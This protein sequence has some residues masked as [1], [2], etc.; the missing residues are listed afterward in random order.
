[1]RRGFRASILHFVADPSVDTDAYQYFDDGLLLI[2]GGRV[3]A[4]GSF[5]ELAAEFPPNQIEDLS[6]RLIVP[7]FIDAHVHFPQLEMIGAYGEALLPWLETYTFPT[8]GKFADSAYARQVAE[9][10]LD[11]LLRHGTTSALVFASVHAAATEALFEAA[12]ARRMRLIAGK[13]LMD[14]NA[15]AYLCDTPET[16]YAESRALIERYH[17]R[18]RLSYAV[19]PRFLA[20]SSPEQLHAAARLLREFPEVYLHTH[21]AE[22]TDEVR[23]VADLFADHAPEGA[24]YLA[25]YD[26][27]G[28][29][30]ERALF[31]HGIHLDDA[32]FALLAAR[33]SALAFCP[34]SNL[35]L[36]SGLF[37]FRAAKAHGVPIALGTDIGA[38]TSLSLLQTLNEAYKVARLRGDR[39]SAFEAFYHATLGAA[40]ALRLE[41]QIGSFQ[42]GREADFV[43]LELAPTPLL[44]FR[45]QHATTLEQKLFVLMTLGDDRNVHATYVAGQLAHTLGA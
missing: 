1:M 27:F 16:G 7:G 33:G 29:L 17:G 30:T 24:S 12:L 2:D 42:P 26:H 9:L 13:V 37:R 21:V 3:L 38:G 28:L 20:T 36:G 11:E 10:F 4:V 5:D 22:N 19:T 39:M 18:E 44:R 35:F 32:D 8:E 41:S 15:P 40:R 45:M 25:T 31:A 6:G 43:V 34:T 14:R 23:W